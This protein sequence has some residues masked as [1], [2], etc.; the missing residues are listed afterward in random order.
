MNWAGSLLG[1]RRPG[2]WLYKMEGFYKEEGGASELSETEK[3][4]LVGFGGKGRA[5]VLACSAFTGA[6]PE[7]S[8]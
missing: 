1:S 3:S 2:G 5:W 4:L 8:D 6:P 7:T